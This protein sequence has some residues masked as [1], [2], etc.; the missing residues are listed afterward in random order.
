MRLE[1]HA[2]ARKVKEPLP[3]DLPS[4]Y[5][6]RPLT[7]LDLLL[8]FNIPFHLSTASHK[9]RSEQC[10]PETLLFLVSSSTLKFLSFWHVV[11]ENTNVPKIGGDD[12]SVMLQEKSQGPNKYSVSLTKWALL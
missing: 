8:C 10:F 1:K 3:L 4:L 6:H 12:I 7:V 5:P 11:K 9:H 2:G